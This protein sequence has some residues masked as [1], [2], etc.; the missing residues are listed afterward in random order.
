MRYATRA[1]FALALAGGCIRERPP[2]AADAGA[3]EALRPSPGRE[4]RGVEEKPDVPGVAVVVPPAP[5]PPSIEERLRRCDPAVS[6]SVVRLSDEHAYAA[7]ATATGAVVRVVRVAAGESVCERYET[8]AGAAQVAWPGAQAPGRVVLATAVGR[9][10]GAALVELGGGGA[11]RSV[12]L[13]E[14]ACTPSSTLRSVQVFAGAPSIQVRCW[15]ATEG[16]WTAVDHIVHRDARGW[17]TLTSSESGR[18]PRPTRAAA[19]PTNPTLPGSIRVAATGASPR[20]EV[21]TSSADVHTGATKFAR[22]T[23]VWSPGEARFRVE[24]TPVIERRAH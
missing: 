13:I 2:P 17:Q 23:L 7:E 3:T 4:L 12:G 19:P 11:V 6:G 8:A 10:S 1:C 24:G 9:A 21:A 16:Y 22:Q 14:G 20:L 18:V 5:P 15:V